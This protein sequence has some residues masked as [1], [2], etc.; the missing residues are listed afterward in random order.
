[1]YGPAENRYIHHAWRNNNGHWNALALQRGRLF[2]EM[3][4]GG[5][6]LDYDPSKPWDD[7]INDEMNPKILATG[8]S[9]IDRPHAL[10]AHPDGRHLVMTGTPAYGHTGGGMFVHDL[11]TGKSEILSHQSLLPNLS[12]VAIEAVD[13]GNT[14]VGVTTIAP[15]TGGKAI[16]KEGELYLMDF[17]ARK[18]IFHEPAIPGASSI[19]GLKVG[20]DSMLYGLASGPNTTFFVFDPKK[21]KVSYQEKMDQYGGITGGQAPR[22][23]AWGPDNKLYICFR[24][25]IV[26]IEPVTFKHRRDLKS[27]VD[28]NV[29]IV[30]REDRAYFA[31]G[32]RLFSWAVPDM[33]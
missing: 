3:Y 14:L 18:I 2:G 30:F 5:Y 26:R 32:S 33:L 16:A 6:L 4:S 25:A 31:C 24:R 15:G 19:S 7:S 20:A 28:I 21:R 12:T 22:V 13:G 23:M 9:D 11:D 27:P 29:G 10:L 1:M 17:A 8:G